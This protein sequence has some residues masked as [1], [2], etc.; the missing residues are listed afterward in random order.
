M[1][2]AKPLALACAV[3]L[4]GTAQLAFAQSA[5]DDLRLDTDTVVDEPPAPAPQPITIGDDAPE[6][7][8][9]RAEAQDPYAAP[10]L[11]NGAFL[12]F[13]SLELS[14]V[15]SSNPRNATSGANADIGLF[16]TPSLRLE[17]DWVRHGFTAD[18][19]VTAEQFIENEDIKSIAGDVG[20]ALRLDIRRTTTAD[21]GFGYSATS[22]GLESSELPATATGNRLDHVISANAGITHDFGGLEGQ[23][24]LGVSRNLFG[25]VDLTGGGEEDNSDRDYTELSIAARA[26]LRTGGLVQPFVEAAY[27]P[28]I[29]DKKQDRNGLK[30]DSQGLRLALG[31]AIDDDPVWS[32]DLAATLALRDY[33][34]D[35]LDTIL[36]PGFAANVT[37]RPT[38]LTQFQFNTGVSLTETVTANVSAQQNW[39]VG[40]TAS[41]AVRENMSLRA[42]ASL[43]LERAA[44]DTDITSVG[45]LGVDWTLNPFVVLSAG[46]E[47]TFFTGA[48]SGDDYADHRLITS[49]V[50]RR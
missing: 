35:S 21:V 25:D 11:R 1:F 31:V 48:G 16:V 23:L 37:W 38:D 5:D 30:R 45:S 41:H 7:P 36:A 42:G 46:Y 13:P 47:G 43:L 18:A 19:S 4:C 39:T 26:G 2:G 10:G 20:A 29:Y 50:L 44:G 40:V 9:R 12:L 24:R 27:E 15:V 22:T 8:R 3:L 32:G 34:D 17:S 49:I 33:S 6:P 14:T 28:R